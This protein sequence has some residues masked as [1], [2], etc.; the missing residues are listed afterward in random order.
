MYTNIN[1]DPTYNFTMYSKT[2]VSL[3]ARVQEIKKNCGVP[4]P[5]IT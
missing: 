2:G 5:I 3:L 1:Q 4:E